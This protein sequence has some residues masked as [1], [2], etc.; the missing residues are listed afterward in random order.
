[1]SKENTSRNTP[2][3]RGRFRASAVVTGALAAFG[4]LL[5]ITLGGLDPG[6]LASPVNLFAGG[7]MVLLCIA[8]AMFADTRFVRWFT[9]VPMAVCLISALGVLALVMGLTPQGATP[10]GGGAMVSAWLGFNA[11]TTSWP[12]VLIYFALLMSLGGLVARRL[13]QFRWR[14]WGFYLNHLGL[15]LTLF[16]AGLGHA[17]IERYMVKV[18]EGATATVG[19]DADTGRPHMLPLAVTLHDFVMEEYPPARPGARPEPKRFASDIDIATPDGRSVRGLTEVN[20]PLRAGSWLAYQYGYDNAAGPRSTYSILEL[21]R[22]PWLGAV[23]AGFAMIA[24]GAL[25]MV[26]SGRK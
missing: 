7:A 21:V 22:D 15:W 25:F 14:D 12:F 5:Q 4:V 10:M 17:D 3:S 6:L 26:W 9:G 11:M 8:V 2:P 18:D 20:H 24:L 19:T 13:A 1:M 23:Y 16:A